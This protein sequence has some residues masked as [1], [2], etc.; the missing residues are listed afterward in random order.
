ME[1]SI[2]THTSIISQA[3]T[4]AHMQQNN[5]TKKNK[6]VLKCILV[7]ILDLLKILF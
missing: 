1:F 3:R 6:Q 2:I 5:N 7:D 4:H